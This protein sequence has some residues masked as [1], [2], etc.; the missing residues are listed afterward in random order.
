MEVREKEGKKITKRKEKGIG[1]GEK[2]KKSKNIE[3][4]ENR[5]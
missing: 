2:G 3:E 1:K 4:K 5:K